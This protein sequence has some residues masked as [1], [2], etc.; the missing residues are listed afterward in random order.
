MNFRVSFFRRL[1]RSTRATAPVALALAAMALASGCATAQDGGGGRSTSLSASVDT[2]LSYVVNS[3]TGGLS[4]GEFVAQVRPGLQLSSRSGR[5]VGSL[6][7]AL[8][9]SHH[10]RNND[11]ENVQHQL[12]G[13]FSAEAI[14][15]W[16]YVDGTAAVS[17]QTVS[18]FGQQSAIGS[19]QD[20]PNRIQVATVSLSP[21]RTAGC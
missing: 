20:N 18:A 6:N 15:R 12:N 11:G 7:Y 13:S 19:T 2:Q 17:Q 9:L 1:R 4:G 8:G 16:M 10:S 5:I 14:E 3:R 21:H